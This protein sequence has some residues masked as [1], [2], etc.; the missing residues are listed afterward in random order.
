V[1]KD[2][3][4]ENVHEQSL[5]AQRRVEDAIRSFGGIKNI[6]ICQKIYTYVR[7][8]RKRYDEYLEESKKVQ[9]EEKTKKVE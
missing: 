2:L 4:V 3:L 9:K 6:P 8:A 1:N 5:I 7:G